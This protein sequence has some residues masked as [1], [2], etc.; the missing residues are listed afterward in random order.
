[1]DIIKKAAYLQGLSEGYQLD[2]SKPENKLLKELLALVSD[3]ADKVVTLEKECAELREYIEEVDEDL[4]LVE[5]E[6]FDLADD[7]DEEDDGVTYEVTRPSCGETVCFDET[8]DPESVIC[9]ACGQSFDCSC[10]FC[11]EED[12][13]GDC[14]CCGKSED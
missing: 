13:D 5:D 11:D 2:E 12:C 9:P 3:L 1:M 6:V 8:V 7:E 10:D 14:E 4:G